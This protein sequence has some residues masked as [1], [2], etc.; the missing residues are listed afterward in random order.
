[1]KNVTNTL[2]SIWKNKYLLRKVT[3]ILLDVFRGIERE[4]LEEKG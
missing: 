1:M 2:K 4:L 3:R